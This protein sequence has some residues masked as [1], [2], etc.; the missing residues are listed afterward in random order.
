MRASHFIAGALALGLAFPLT[1]AAQDG[2]SPSIL[3]DYSAADLLLPCMEADS[4]SRETGVVAALE[5]EQYLT[6]F[7][8]ALVATGQ[9]GTEA[10]ICLP[11]DNVPDE[12]R[13]AYVRWVHGAYRER[14]QMPAKEA[15]LAT[16][17]EE[18][19]CQ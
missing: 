14:T 12:I 16:I 8:S 5:C 11:E 13:W 10:G 18:F 6:G 7:A 1:A 17:K 4:D 3:A 19:A 15:V 2:G 9:T